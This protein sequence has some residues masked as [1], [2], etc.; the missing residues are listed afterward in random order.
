MAGSWE[1]LLFRVRRDGATGYTPTDEQ[2]ADYLR[3]HSPEMI[4][5]LKD[6]GVN[7]VMAHAFKGAG[8]AA[9]SE[10]MA[11]AAAF[12]KR[13]R[14]AGL[15]VGVYLGSGTLLWELLFQEAPQAKDWVLLNANGEPLTYGK[16]VWRHFWNRN[17]PDGA[18]YHRQVVRHA[19][20]QIGADLVHFDNYIRGPGWDANSQDRFRE[21]LGRTFTAQE[22]KQ[23]G[24][25]DVAAVRAP[26]A[27]P[28]DSLLGRAWLDFSCQS[29]AE[30][31]WDVCRYARS[32]RQDVL[33]ECNPGGVGAAIRPPVDHGRLLQGGEALWDEGS[34]PGF[35]DGKLTSSIRTY[36][37]ARRMNNLTFRYTI[38]PLEMAES[39]AFNLD[40][41]GCVCWFEYGRLATMPGV[42]APPLET[43]A[44]YIKFFHARRDLLRDANVVADVAVL[45]SFPSQVFGKPECAQLTY[46][47]EESLIA[48]RFP[49]QILYSQQ[50]DDLGRY[51]AVVLAGCVALSDAHIDQLRRYVAA[52]GRLCV[53]GPAATHDQ[54][55][56]PRA[57]PALDGLPADR[58]WRIPQ[59]GD[60]ASAIDQAVGGR[61]LVVDGPPGVCAELTQQPGR[62]LAHLVNYRGDGPAKNVAVRLRLPTGQT[63]KSV[64]L[65]SPDRSADLTAPYEIADGYV[66]FTI[67]AIEVYE[68]AA[69]TLGDRP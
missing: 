9:E 32:L 38:R 65:A 3:E 45:R 47:V 55:M 19:V 66:Q 18:A 7:F 15:H 30:S 16:A 11:D 61:S 49:F 2:K 13:C 43:L 25:E 36:K 52:G 14:E 20:Q 51:R 50:L 12:A 5:K 46:Q 24:V 63:V 58:V 4:A 22:L 37:V 59:E 62:R 54:W 26:S 34:R 29:L 44:P 35:R 67:P 23:A 60:A 53:I 56:R 57:K 17:H 33:I 69:V 10:S 31:Y 68:I 6:L 8:M 28:A 42:E 39:M 27:D 41:L 40:C 64:T 48:N 1:P 21:Y